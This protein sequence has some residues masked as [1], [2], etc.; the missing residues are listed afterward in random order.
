MLLGQIKYQLVFR[1][2][3]EQTKP[4]L[5]ENIKEKAKSGFSATKRNFLWI[6]PFWPRLFSP[7]FL[8]PKGISFELL[9][10]SCASLFLTCFKWPR[11]ES[12]VPPKGTSFNLPTQDSCH[13]EELPYRVWAPKRGTFCIIT[14]A[15]AILYFGLLKDS[16]QVKTPVSVLSVP[17]W[18]LSLTAFSE[19]S[20]IKL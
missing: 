9:A 20:H 13:Q 17:T 6:F 18:T 4:G 2:D 8:P 1:N 10:P 5:F 12:L 11:R 19:Y 16:K 7:R 3:A 14:C 15:Q